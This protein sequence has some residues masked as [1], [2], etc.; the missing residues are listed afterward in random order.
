M[1]EYTVKRGTATVYKLRQGGMGVGWADVTIREWPG[2]GSI[3]IQSDYGDYS[4]FWN[5][6]GKRSFK[7]FLLGLN[8]GYFFG[9]CMGNDYK[10]HDPEGTEKQLKKVIIELRRE[11]ELDK[12]SA[13]ECWDEMALVDFYS[14]ESY[15]HSIVESDLWE[16]VCGEDHYSVPYATKPAPQAEA[17][18]EIIWPVVCEIWRQEEMQDAA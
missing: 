9:K 14:S 3:D 10:V 17:F 11:G 15:Y 12:K 4:Y 6:I 5:S 13:R 7:D 2:G 18:W 1:A 16:T 8:P